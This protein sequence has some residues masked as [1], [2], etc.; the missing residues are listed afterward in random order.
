MKKYILLLFVSIFICQCTPNVPQNSKINE[1]FYEDLR[2]ENK[3][4]RG[5]L[6]LDKFNQDLDSLTYKY[7]IQYLKDSPQQS[8][9]G[10]AE[11]IESADSNYFKARPN[12][13]LMALMYKSER[14]IIVDDAYTAKLDTVLLIKE[15]ESFPNL[16]EFAQKFWKKN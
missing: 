12:S 8:A 1:S 5:T 11:L 9:K 13:F 10:L 3:R 15:G 7:Y 16:E 4:V 14:K 6:Y 2:T